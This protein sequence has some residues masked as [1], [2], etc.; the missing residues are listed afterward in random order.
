MFAIIQNN[1]I[2]LLVP[3]GTAFEWDDIQYPANWC[4][5]SSP[6]EKAAI[7]MVDVVYGQYPND[8][9]YWVS[10]DA[11][12]Y[13][14]TV[15]EINYTATPKDLFECQMQ[16]VNAVQAQAYSILLPS[17]W[18]VVKGYE[19]KSAISPAWN[20]WRQD[21]RTQCDAQIIAI[22]GCTTVAEL[23]ALPSVVWAH[24]PNW[25]PPAVQEDA[26]AI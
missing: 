18:R 17:D 5:L 15:V 21:I 14:G 6:E 12:V 11:P 1:L 22:N 26:P 13:N 16:A 7:G 23:A 2:A 20:T 4:N 9:Y 19:T 24:D 10:Q 3:A 8:Q 25:I